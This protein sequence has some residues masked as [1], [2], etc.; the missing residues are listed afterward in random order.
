[1]SEETGSYFTLEREADGIG[2]LVVANPRPDSVNTISRAFVEGLEAVLPSLATDRS[3]RGLVVISGKPD[4][5]VGADLKEIESIGS[6]DEVIELHARIRRAFD[7]CA[8]LPYPT[9][10]A[11]AGNAPGGGLEWALLWRYRVLASDPPAKVSQAEVKVGLIP[12]AGGTQRLPRRIGLRAALELIL[13]GKTV[14]PKK[15]LAL[16][17]ADDIVPE[18]MLRRAALDLV[19]RD[20]R[21]EPIDRRFPGV[22]EAL[23]ATG[24]G[25]ALLW[26]LSL[27]GVRKQTRG[28]YPAPE[29]ALRAA[30][31]GAPL[32][33][34]EAL[35]L[36]GKAFYPM[37]L[38]PVSCALRHVG[39]HATMALKKRVSLDPAPGRARDVDLLGIV[40]GGFMGSG[41][42]QVAIDAGCRVHVVDET[43]AAI[44]GALAGVHAHLSAK[45]KRGILKRHELPVAMGHLV[46]GLDHRG[47]KHAPLVIE[48]VFE[49]LDL[50]RKVLHKVEEATAG[51]AVFASNTSSLS[52]ADIGRDARHPENVIGMHFFSPVAKMPLLE[53]IVPARAS[54]DTVAIAVAFGR[55]LGKHVIV[56]RDKVG[57]YTTRVAG[58]FLNEVT[59]MFMEGA[60]VDG[61]DRA[62]VAAG[63]PTGP[64]QL[65]D[66]VGIDVGAKVNKI[67]HD[68][69]G[70]RLAPPAGWQLVLTPGR[71]GRRPGSTG[72]YLYRDGKRSGVDT[73]V[74]HATPTGQARRD[75]PRDEIQDRALYM[76]VAE[77]IRCLEEAV[78][79]G[80]IE[81]DVGAVFGLGFPPHLGGPFFHVDRTGPRRV[82]EKLSELSRR[83]GPRFDPPA[84]L[85][86]L[87]ER[88]AT[89]HAPPGSGSY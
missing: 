8:D 12:G 18:P 37:V 47:L 11:V 20:L 25:R 49:D 19:R 63:F 41:I 35:T 17:I 16:G 33:L 59:H 65:L 58:A 48:A 7:R 15:A 3:L 14:Y 36:E 22:T 61:I 81:G 34:A 5:L 1:V 39:F 44:G 6:L 26:R 21:A 24:P 38:D 45:V 50:K 9:C 66:E 72:F 13:T 79:P 55:R 53:V 84:L 75:P 42:A 83:H 78:L 46:G 30:L 2:V 64:F 32:P 4:W 67:L 73:T 69:F 71:R 89:F 85:R 52:I 70:D 87:A 88:G 77:A 68:A 57:F 76:F 27:S 28:L 62:I 60:S 29:I 86:D 80:P 56:V 23:A 40:G 31:E 43:P 82:L 10:A 54:A 51:S 74:Y